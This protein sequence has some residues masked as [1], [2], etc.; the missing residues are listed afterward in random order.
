MVIDWII[1]Y[2]P[3]PTRKSVSVL[4][5]KTMSLYKTDTPKQT[6]SWREK[7][8]SKPRKQSVYGEEQKQSMS[9]IYQNIKKLFISEENKKTEGWIIRDI[10]KLLGTEEE[11]EERKQS[12]KKEKP[13]ERLIKNK[14]IRD[15][16]TLYEEEEEYMPK[17]VSN[18]WN[19]NYI[20][21]ESNGDKNSKL[22]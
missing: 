11:K 2:I 3:E 15:I 17:I 8:L 9:R 1:N 13:N 6:V 18:L 19:N 22:D 16:R 14:I 12:E 10:W 4:K 5:D 7:K 20:E 21:Y